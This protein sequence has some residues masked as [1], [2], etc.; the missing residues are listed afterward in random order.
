MQGLSPPCLCL[1]NPQHQELG[2]VSCLGEETWVCF[3]VAVAQVKQ[4]A[5][6][7]KD[8]VVF[9][10]IGGGEKSAVLEDRSV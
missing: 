1:S 7:F 10:W 9:V 8:L 6:E 5:V 3:L 2:G 4:C